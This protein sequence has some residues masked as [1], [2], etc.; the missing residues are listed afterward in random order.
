MRLLVVGVA[1]LV[2]CFAGGCSED[3][4]G[5]SDD[6]Q[7]MG[8]GEISLADDAW[9]S[10]FVS[11][12]DLVREAHESDAGFLSRQL[13]VERTRFRLDG[14]KFW[15]EFPDDQ[16]RYEW[17]AITRMIPPEMTVF[18]DANLEVTNQENLPADSAV[19]AGNA[20]GKEPVLSELDIDMSGRTP[21]LRLLEFS[22]ILHL[23]HTIRASEDPSSDLAM[24][25][26]LDLAARYFAAHYEPFDVADREN[27]SLF[28]EA[29]WRFVFATEL[30][31]SSFNKKLI[32]RFLDKIEEIPTIYSTKYDGVSR[33]DR[34]RAFVLDGNPLPVLAE[35]FALREASDSVRQFWMSEESDQNLTYFKTPSFATR[36]V[37]CHNLLLL[38]RL[39]QDAAHRLHSVYDDTI[40]DRLTYVRIQTHPTYYPIDPWNHLNECAKY[41]AA[42]TEI[43]IE[44]WEHWVATFELLGSELLA[45][46]GEGQDFEHIVMRQISAKFEI[47]PYSAT[48]GTQMT[49]FRKVVENLRYLEE[50]GANV[51]DVALDLSRLSRDG[52]SKFGL[53][54]GDV[55]EVLL[56]FSSLEVA[57]YQRV[58]DTFDRR[59]SLRDTPFELEATL[60]DGTPFNIDSLIGNI[61]LVDHW[62][63]G[64]IPCIN[65][66]PLIDEVFQEYRDEGFV[67]VSLAYDAISKRQRVNRVK[68]ELGLDDWISVNAEPIK[69][70]MY[71]K[72]DI[73]TFPQYMLLNR[74]GT[75]YAGT[76]EVALGRNLA[77]LL[78]EMLAAEAVE[79]ETTVVH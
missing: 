77:D 60:L 50:R 26:L 6:E 59:A 8:R 53:S 23:V 36:F 30:G 63:T 11:K 57:E 65:A 62:N 32:L 1:T 9:E 18:A 5:K 66:M 47:L 51:N 76:E 75:L 17:L 19:V 31:N 40:H 21:K 54:A 12:V 4:R 69:D 34:M 24:E 52:E 29:V 15:H 68:Q 39:H 10:L 71:Q 48:L 42:V 25:R 45:A 33:I 74:D 49:H 46:A 7:N 72:Y 37:R 58:L 70:V 44:A 27:A 3:T 73:W 64:C 55:R 2:M 22:E 67:V 28:L 38:N 13:K 56:E 43:D 61:V 41:F 35:R 79:K 78:D 14:L 16:R 20:A